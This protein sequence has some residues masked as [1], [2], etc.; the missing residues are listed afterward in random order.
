MK[1]KPQPI[2]KD[3]PTFSTTLSNGRVITMRQAITQDLLMLQT[4]D[5]SEIE[6][7]IY[8]MARLSQNSDPPLTEADI[9]V[10]SVK[11]FQALSALVAKCT[12]QGEEEENPFE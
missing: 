10:L 4:G 1:L 2:P 5:R 11:D 9:Q 3:L 12:G 8:M 7:G 6:Q